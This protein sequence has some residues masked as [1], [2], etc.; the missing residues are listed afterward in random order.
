MNGAINMP[1]IERKPLPPPNSTATAI[2]EA[3]RAEIIARANDVIDYYLNGPGSYW[4]AGPR[5]SL[6]NEP[7]VSTVTDLKRYRDGVIASQQF[8]DDPNSILDSVIELINQA[9]YQVKTAAQDSE[10][11]DDIWRGPPR[12]DDPIDDPRVT[13]PRELSNKLSAISSPIASPPRPV[14]PKEFPCAEWA[15]RRRIEAIAV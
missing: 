2:T 8:A 4:Q 7:G 9:I 15:D 14:D 11:R 12:T 5:K 10:G 6:L 3:D 1:T 13:S